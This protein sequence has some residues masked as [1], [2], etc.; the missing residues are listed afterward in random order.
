MLLGIIDHSRK[1][2]EITCGLPA[3]TDSVA[4]QSTF[5][6]GVSDL[7]ADI[8]K[9]RLA[10]MHQIAY[11]GE[12]HSHPDGASTAPSVIDCEQLAYLRQEFHGQQR[13]TV[14]LIVGNSE[15]NLIFQGIGQ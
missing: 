6:R 8:D 3:P 5:E 11:V 9:A 14:M 10:T 2:I 1:R 12:W 4:T 15:A 7:R 13:P